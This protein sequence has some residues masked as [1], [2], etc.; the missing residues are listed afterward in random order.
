MPP[1]PLDAALVDAL[2]VEELAPPAPE[3][4]LAALVAPPPAPTEEGDVLSDEEHARVP[5]A[6]RSDAKAYRIITAALYLD[7]VLEVARRGRARHDAKPA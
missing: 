2:A 4:V 3:A 5:A 6:R 7:R 1:A